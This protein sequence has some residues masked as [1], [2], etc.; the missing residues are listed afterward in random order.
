[1]RTNKGA[2]IALDAF[3]RVPDRYLDGNFALMKQMFD[4][5]FPEGVEMITF[6]AKDRKYTYPSWAK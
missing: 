1:M 2:L 6:N 5:F 4:A 3:L